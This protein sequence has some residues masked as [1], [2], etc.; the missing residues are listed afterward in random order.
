[1][2]KNIGKWLEEGKLPKTVSRYGTSIEEIFTCYEELKG[3]Y[4]EAMKDIPLG[5][6]GVYTFSQKMQVGLQ[7]IMAGSRN[8]RL[9]TITRNDLMALTEEAAQVSGI[10]YV[11]NAYR[12]KAEAILDGFEVNGYLTDMV[13]IGEPTAILSMLREAGQVEHVPASA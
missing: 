8:F 13:P 12:Q 7:Q 11:M 10:P 1:M 6:I 4:G 5:A 2:G 9:S 3:I